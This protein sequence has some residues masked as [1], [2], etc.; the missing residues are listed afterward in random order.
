M[1]NFEE[2]STIYNNIKNNYNLKIKKNLNN[3]LLEYDEFISNDNSL[4]IILKKRE[5][6]IVWIYAI[7]ILFYKYYLISKIN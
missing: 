4:I 2:F 3:I 7:L 6:K 1:I 5:S